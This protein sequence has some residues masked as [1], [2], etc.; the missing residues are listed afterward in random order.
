[1]S[2]DITDRTRKLVR[3][4]GLSDE[5]VASDDDGLSVVVEARKKG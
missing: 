3:R 1:M 4:A 5:G 2:D